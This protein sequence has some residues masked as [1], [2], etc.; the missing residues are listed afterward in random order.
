MFLFSDPGKTVLC[1]KIILFVSR[2]FVTLQSN[3]LLLTMVLLWRPNEEGKNECQGSLVVEG[4]RVWWSLQQR[5]EDSGPSRHPGS[6]AHWLR[7]G[8]SQ[9]LL[10]SKAEAA[11][12][13]LWSATAVQC[14]KASSSKWHPL[15]GLEVPSGAHLHAATPANVPQKSSQHLTLLCCVI[16]CET[17][18]S[19]GLGCKRNND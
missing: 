8:R 18:P 16:P 5:W 9:C 3:R 2:K 17:W 19:T 10:Q 1:P 13:R 4:E 14:N 6:C 7:H 11:Q 12:L 15:L